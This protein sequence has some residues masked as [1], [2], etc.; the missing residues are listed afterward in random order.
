MVGPQ[1]VEMPRHIIAQVILSK[2]NLYATVSCPA[3][4]VQMQG[5][6]ELLSKFLEGLDALPLFG[7]WPASASRKIPFSLI[8][9]PRSAVVRVCAHPKDA[10]VSAD[11]LVFRLRL[12][13]GLGNSPRRLTFSLTARCY[14]VVS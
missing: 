4:R 10:P 7:E 11:E 1:A 5:P 8:H 6:E 3:L 12:H 2:L 14:P 13:L 9:R